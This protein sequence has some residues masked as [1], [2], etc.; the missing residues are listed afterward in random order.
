MPASRVDPGRL[1][2]PAWSGH[3][4]RGLAHLCHA[5]NRLR[6]PDGVPAESRKQDRSPAAVAVLRF[7]TYATRRVV[8]P[9]DA[10]AVGVKAL[11]SIHR[12]YTLPL[13]AGRTRGPALISQRVSSPRSAQ[14]SC[15]PAARLASSSGVPVI[16]RV[17][18]GVLQSHELGHAQPDVVRPT[19]RPA[20]FREQVSAR[21]AARTCN[22]R[23]A[24]VY[25]A[26]ADG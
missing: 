13:V 18:P 14:T 2:S 21:F 19:R 11:L 8:D 9:P 6:A 4:A 22:A 12:V 10:T 23:K 26:E 3:Q 5:C 16:A 15:S 25:V 1:P 20:V 7:A 17:E 24:E